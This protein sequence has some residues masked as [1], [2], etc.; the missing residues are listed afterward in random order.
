[1]N[2]TVQRFLG[3]GIDIPALP[4]QAAEGRLDMGARAAEAVVKIEM[5]ECGVE[6]VAPK[7]ADD[8]AAKPDA[9]RIAGR[10]RQSLVASAISSIFF[11]LSLAAS[12]VGFCGS[13]GLAAAALGEGRS[14]GEDKSRRA[15]HGHKLT[16]RR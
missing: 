14:R 9:F 6:V 5:A 8:A 2:P 15:K 16:Q 13:G 3:L 11:W 12:A 10:P 4:D 1:M 7:Q